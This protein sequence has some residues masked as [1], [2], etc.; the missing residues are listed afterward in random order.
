M[1]RLACLV[2]SLFASAAFAQSAAEVSSGTAFANSIRATSNSQIVNPS[3]VS[4]SAWS[5]GTG[6]SS[7]TPPGLGGFSSPNTSSSYLNQAQSSS[8]TALGNQAMINC[9]NYTPGSDPYQNQYCAAVNFL[10]NQCMQPTT[11][12]KSILGVTGTTQGSASNCAGTYGAGQ[13]QYSYSDQVT[14][15]D[16]MFS[17]TSG[18]ATAAS[19]TLTQTCTPQTVVTQPAQYEY[20]TCVVSQNM[21]DNT[22]SQYLSASVTKTIVDAL[23]NESC[24]SGSTLENGMCVTQSYSPPNGNCPPGESYVAIWHAAGTDSNSDGSYC[25]GTTTTAGTATCST[26]TLTN[27]ECYATWSSGYGQ[28]PSITCPS[29]D[30]GMALISCDV[31]CSGDAG[32]GMEIC[33]ARG[34]YQATESCPAGFTWDGSEC[35]ETTTTG[36]SSYSCPSGSLGGSDGTACVTTT[37]TDP[38]ITYSCP[39][40][41]TLS[42][43]NCIETTTTTSWSD[44]C[45]IYEQSAGKTL[46]TPTQ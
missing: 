7:T 17:S 3:A 32:R 23:E 22:C 46:P 40:G 9:A 31:S 15:S 10:N 16:P 14:S 11:G 21:E 39:A 41:E 24:P 33:H 18:L 38:I 6:I 26:G 34:Y 20:D 42:N 5:S 44:T 1:K 37:T 45:V 19:D 2:L 4:S 13:G 28:H 35:T 43:T 30:N 29:T 8:L 27:G 25:Q 36:V 12:E